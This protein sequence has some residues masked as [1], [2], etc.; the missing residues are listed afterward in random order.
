MPIN[1]H[2]PMRCSACGVTFRNMA[3]MGNHVR[4]SK[5]CTPEARFWGL[6]DKNAPNGC[7]NWTASR[8]QKGYGQFWMGT[9]MKRTH[10]LSWELLRGEIPEGLHV[11]HNCDNRLCVNPDHLRLGTHQENIAEMIAKGRNKTKLTPAKVREI[12]AIEGM[13]GKEIAKQYG[14]SDSTISS[15]RRGDK[16]K[17]V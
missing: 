15:I 10:R 1:N 11:L 5:V 12:R 7:W 17:N 3:T 14:V 16:W 4:Y 8:R 13:L 9:T 2:N 6:V